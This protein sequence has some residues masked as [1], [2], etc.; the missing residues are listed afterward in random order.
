MSAVERE[1][2]M[3]KLVDVHR[4]VERKQ[5]RDRDRQQL[6]VQ[7]RLSIIQSRKADEDLFGPKHKERMRHL[8][9]DIPQSQQKTL[10]REQLEQLKR[11]RSF[12]M[13][14]RR[15]RYRITVGISSPLC[16]GLQ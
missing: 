6:R 1:K 5:Q 7:E 10:V 15:K 11:E 3:R 12:I 9:K 4:R 13:Q 2:T 8:S 16:D 14:S